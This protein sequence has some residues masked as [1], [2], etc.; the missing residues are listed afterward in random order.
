MLEAIMITLYI[1][2]CGMWGMFSVNMQET[3]YSEKCSFLRIGGVFF[4]NAILCPVSMIIALVKFDTH[5]SKIRN[6]I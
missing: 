1:I 2:V 5:I 3:I 6:K 4:L